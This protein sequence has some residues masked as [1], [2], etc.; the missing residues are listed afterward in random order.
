MI[1]ANINI[2]EPL[3]ENLSFSLEGFTIFANGKD[4]LPYIVCTCPNKSTARASHG[5]L[6]IAKKAQDLPGI[7]GYLTGDAALVPQVLATGQ[8]VLPIMTILNDDT[9]FKDGVGMEIEGEFIEAGMA[10]YDEFIE[11]LRKA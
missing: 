9:I 10:G 5:L 7:C 3:S 6:E 8:A 1:F 4:G 11:K 2:E